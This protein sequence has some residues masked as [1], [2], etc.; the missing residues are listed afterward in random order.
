MLHKQNLVDFERLK[1]CFLRENQANREI[2]IAKRRL[3][4]KF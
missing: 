3:A 4:K 2:Q 1:T